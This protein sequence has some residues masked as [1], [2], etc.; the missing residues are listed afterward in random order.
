[1]RGIIN[2]SPS[3]FTSTINGEE[4]LG[5][6]ALPSS[7]VVAGF[8]PALGQ[9]GSP[10]PSPTLSPFGHTE[11]HCFP[12]MLV[13]ELTNDW[14]TEEDSHLPSINWHRV[15]TALERAGF[16]FDRQMTVNVQS[17]LDSP[18]WKP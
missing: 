5:G 16:V 12:S 3:P 11:E 15:A 18:T 4:V 14:S 8:I 1:M 2:A 6:Y 17:N 10:T 13:L 7:H 9:S